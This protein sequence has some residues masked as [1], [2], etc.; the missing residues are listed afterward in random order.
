M[1]GHVTA[2]FEPVADAFAALDF[3]SGGGA[4]AAVVDGALVADL[5]TGVRVPGVPW[6][7][8]TRAVLMSATKGL[9]T[10]CAQ[11]L[12]D[13]GL[14]ALEQPVAAYWP[15][16]ASNGKEGVLVR[17]VLSHTSGVVHLPGYDELLSWDGAGWDDGEEITAR[18]AKARPAWKPGSQ[19]GY[20][21]LT[22]GWLVGE[23][24]RRVAGMSLGEFFAA[25]VAKPLGLDA[26]IGTPLADQGRVAVPSPAPEL[27]LPPEIAALF[28][29]WNDPATVQGQA[30]FAGPEGNVITNIAAFMSHPRVLAAE[31]GG[32]NGT[33]TAS[34]LARM[35]ALLACEGELDGVRVL[36]PEVVGLFAREQAFGPDAIGIVPFRWALGY[37]RHQPSELP[38]VPDQMGPND[39]AF[40]HGGLGGQLGFADP[41][42]RVGVGF[43]RSHLEAPH[44]SAGF[45]VD[46]LYRCL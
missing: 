30:F 22:F 24:V 46:A 4:F 21:A 27:D 26:A 23:V 17:H 40:G 35:Y 28:A 45:V 1:P 29:S 2:G 10:L 13:R 37:S 32:S 38:G 6:G 41:V 20:H 5:W 8:D 42:A 44:I 12:V 7:Q 16:F 33:A 36:S 3:G 43:V 11:L 9:T 15:E 34:S 18:L 31:L 14:L 25:E 19:H 39:E